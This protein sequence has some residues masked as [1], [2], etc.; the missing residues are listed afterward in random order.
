LNDRKPTGT[1][2]FVK[3]DLRK[4]KLNLC[5]LVR[6][7]SDKKERW[8]RNTYEK[9]HDYEDDIQTHLL[10]RQ[11]LQEHGE[12][13]LSVRRAEDAEPR[14]AGQDGIPCRNYRQEAPQKVPYR[15]P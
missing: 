7:G 14:G 3:P 6:S 1:I 15:V 2:F 5:C 8:I 10:F 11:D 9:F 13:R 12:A 4:N